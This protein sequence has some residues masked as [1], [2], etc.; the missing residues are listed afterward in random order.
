MPLLRGAAR[1]NVVDL[2]MSPLCESFLPADRL[3]EMEPFYPLHVRVC[4]ALL[5]RAAAGVRRRPRRSST[6]YAYF[7]AYSDSWVEHARG[8][9]DMITRRGSAS[10]PTASSSSSPRTTA[11]CCST[12]CRRAS[13]CSAS[14]RRRT[15]REAAEERGVPTLVEFFGVEL[16]RAARRASAARA[17]LVAR[18]QRARAGA[19]PERLRRAA[20]RSCCAPDGDG[21]VRVPAPRCGCSKGS[22]TTRSTTSTSRTS[23]STTIRRG[24][25]RA[26][27]RRLRRRGAADARRLAARLRAAR[28]R[29]RTAPSPRSRELLAR[30]EASGLR[31]RRSATARFAERRRGVEARAARAPDRAQARG[32][33][34]RRLRRARQ[35]QHAAQLLRH[36]HRL[37]RLHGRPQPV[38][39][40]PLHAGHAHP[41][42]SA[43]ADRRDAAGL[44]S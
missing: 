19:R 10:A 26:R 33:A 20:S 17:D 34:G 36:P 40:R 14:T 38:Q 35:G 32:Q 24:L 21:D 42:P 11:T 12:S 31:D 25:R 7:S 15:S 39:A 28:R 44:R 23:R 8:Y 16:A 3:E 29:P 18:Q 43:R 30:E 37:P 6:E 41:D 1:A 13:R 27:A 5:A 9:V 4:D 22:S 2:G